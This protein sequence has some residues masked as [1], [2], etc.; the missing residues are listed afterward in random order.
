MR[1]IELG[2]ACQER[3]APDFRLTTGDG[4]TV[5]RAQFRHRSHLILIFLPDPRAPEAQRLLA[6][7]ARLRP[8]L[9]HADATVYAVSPGAQA[10]EAPVP[11]LHDSGNAVCRR[12]AALLPEAGRPASDEPFIIILDRYGTLA[13]AA[14]GAVDR[15]GIAEEI[16]S[17]VQGIQH[18]CPE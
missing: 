14:R 16:L 4:K 18:E 13:H 12:Y 1:W 2:R 8:R 10:G 17:W 3:L 9:G 6:D 7:V 5:T 11:V 15:R